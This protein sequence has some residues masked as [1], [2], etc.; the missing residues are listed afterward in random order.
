MK[1]KLIRKVTST[2]FDLSACA[3]F[4]NLFTIH[5]YSSENNRLEICA[6][7]DEN[8]S[9]SDE[10]TNSSSSLN[11]QEDSTPSH[12]SKTCLS[13]TSFFHL[14]E[15]D[16]V[17]SFCIVP[18]S[19]LF[20]ERNLIVCI[21]ND[22]SKKA[23]Y[24]NRTI[25][26]SEGQYSAR[27]VE[28]DWQ[29]PFDK[30]DSECLMSSCSSGY[31]AFYSPTHSKL[32]ILRILC[33]GSAVFSFEKVMDV[34][35]FSRKAYSLQL[36]HSHVVLGQLNSIQVCDWRYQQVK[37]SSDSTSAPNLKISGSIIYLPKTTKTTKKKSK[38]ASEKNGLLIPKKETSPPTTDKDSKEA[39]AT[40]S[41]PPSTEKPEETIVS[42]IS[43]Q[44]D[45]RVKDIKSIS[46]NAFVILSSL[47]NLYLLNCLMPYDG[48]VFVKLS[49]PISHE[50]LSKITSFDVLSSQL[51]PLYSSSLSAMLALSFENSDTVVVT[52]LKAVYSYLQ[53]KQ[54]LQAAK[55]T[56]VID[57]GIDNT[58]YSTDVV[59]GLCLSAV[60]NL[61]VADKKE[62][63]MYQIT[64]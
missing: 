52:S 40:A 45:E 21:M 8:S 54:S 3:S 19:T 18:L 43:K 37:N 41:S 53:T 32:H 50:K 27:E 7:I 14:F 60:N 51:E 55:E 2:N 13:S 34:D 28:I 39:T 58:L 24:V 11:H 30:L 23:I 20:E 64:I 47:G 17:K 46:N 10:K 29:N 4:H 9:S 38:A 62:L 35:M 48:D 26:S 25:A 12:D 31:F 61:V 5:H 56:A 57:I 63:C 36:T 49:L 15:L 6:L 22:N 59:H 44:R 33:Q 1:S 42:T 16:G